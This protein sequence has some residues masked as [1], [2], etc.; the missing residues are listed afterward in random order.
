MTE[1][2]GQRT[3]NR[4]QKTAGRKQ[5]KDER[6]PIFPAKIN[7]PR[8]IHEAIFIDLGYLVIFI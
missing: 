7:D 6:R 3:E 2:R 5:R 4:E 8:M 1:V